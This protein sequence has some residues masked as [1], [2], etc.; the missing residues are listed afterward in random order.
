VA[1]IEEAKTGGTATRKVLRIVD[2]TKIPKS[3]Y[4]C[5]PDKDKIQ[6]S[7][8]NGLPVPGTSWEDEISIVVRK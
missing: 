2:E 3:F 7:W 4:I 1:K 6:A 8:R 5:E